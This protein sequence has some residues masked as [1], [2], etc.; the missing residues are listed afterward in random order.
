MIDPFI[1]VGRLG[2]PVAFSLPR[3]VQACRDKGYRRLQSQHI[4]PITSM[5]RGPSVGHKEVVLDA[6]TT[7]FLNDAAS[8]TISGI[9]CSC[10]LT[11]V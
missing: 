2:Y 9:T 1:F 4:A 6:S 5:V 11:L 10:Q 3:D 7:C 8:A